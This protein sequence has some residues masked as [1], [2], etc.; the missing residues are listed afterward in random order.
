MI[1]YYDSDTILDAVSKNIIQATVALDT[2]QMGELSVKAL[3]EY[4]ETGYTN[5]YMAVD[6]QVITPDEAEELTE[7]L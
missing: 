4:V 7:Q 3:D 5:G 6:I 1:G 2:A